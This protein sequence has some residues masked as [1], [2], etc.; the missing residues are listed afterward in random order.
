VL[1]SNL[2]GSLTASLQGIMTY[3]SRIAFSRF[4]F[5]CTFLSILSSML[6]AKARSFVS[7]SLKAAAS[8]NL[9]KYRLVIHS[10]ASSIH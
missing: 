6:L 3:A 8:T 5:D 7:R 2:S 4:V 9:R 1:E 10:S